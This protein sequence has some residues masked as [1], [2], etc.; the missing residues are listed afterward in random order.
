MEYIT[1]YSAPVVHWSL[2]PAS[3]PVSREILIERNI[4]RQ[5]GSA[6]Y[7]FS[8]LEWSVLCTARGVHTEHSNSPQTR[9]GDPIREN[10]RT[11][12]GMNAQLTRICISGKAIKECSSIPNPP[13]V[14][15]LSLL[16]RLILLPGCLYLPLLRCP[17]YCM[18]LLRP[19]PGTW[20]ICQ[21][22]TPPPLWFS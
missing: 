20:P 11:M 19:V 9:K 13:R 15:L 22:S 3:R 10:K 4:K 21:Q 16:L 8:L 18:L 7:V 5:T 1:C 6:L 14:V 2:L 17:A 12:Y